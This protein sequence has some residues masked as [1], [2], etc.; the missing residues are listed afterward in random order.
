[1]NRSKIII[2]A[3]AVDLLFAT[4]F[5]PVAQAL[6]PPAFAAYQVKLEITRNGISLGTPESTVTT[7]ESASMELSAAR[8]ARML[9]QQRVTEFPGAGETKALLEL[10]LYGVS[11][12]GSQ[13]IVA[14]T[15]GIDLGR[16]QVYQWETEQGL[17]SVRA[18][19]DGLEAVPNP[20]ASGIQTTPYPEV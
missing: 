4:A 11:G 7:G 18:R 14:P 12:A 9:L 15:V 6:A 5:A 19:V 2:A 3:F 20:D 16:S 10:E 8:P 17:I 13:R 1:M